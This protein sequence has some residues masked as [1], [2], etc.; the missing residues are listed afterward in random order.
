VK[1]LS[2]A[3]RA[4]CAVLCAAAACG[5]PP[6]EHVAGR[7]CAPRGPAVPWFADATAASGVD[8]E[9]LAADFR[10]GPLAVADTDGDG[11]LDL[12]AGSR[13]GGLAHFRNRGGWSFVD[14]AGA[15][16]LDLETPVHYIAPADLDNDGDPDLAVAGDRILLFE[17]VGR[18]RFTAVASAGDLGDGS[19]VEHLLPVDLDGDG[20]LELY[21]SNRDR[22]D[23]ER[24]RNRLF[25]N[26][27]DLVLAE[28]PG[29]GG[30]D[31]TGLSWTASAIDFDGDGDLDLHVANDTLVAD[32][33][34]SRPVGTDLPPDAFYR[35]DTRP[36]EIRLIDVAADL[37][38]D[39]PRSSMGGLVADF[40]GDRRLDLFIT[41]FGRKKL[42][43]GTAGGFEER[44]EA[45]GVAGT[46]RSDGICALAANQ[47]SRACLLLSWGSQLADFDLDGHDD[48][49]VVNGVSEIDGIPAPALVFR[50]PPPFEEIDAGLG[51]FEGHGLIAA[52]LDDDGDL[53]LA[54]G[55]HNGPL[56]LFQNQTDPIRPSLVLSLEGRRSNREGLGAVIE[57]R[58]AAGRRLVR[59][60]GAGGVSHSAPPPLVHVGLGDD[61][62]ASIEIRWPSG[63]RQELLAPYDPHVIA[64]EPVSPVYSGA[65]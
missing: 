55:T 51:C 64:A 13:S 57:V 40:D 5:D 52:D 33:G 1:R 44:G 18:G 23:P 46:T 30:G 41:D 24:S 49:V 60:L 12:L 31:S 7:P 25:H 6:P 58:T 8:F 20:L 50:G 19:A 17:N 28:V 47:L 10:G 4:A 22:H 65:R 38:L 3:A 45:L 59:A 37:G 42:F 26:R 16:G 32:H 21:V 14:D 53:D 62:A 11:R 61:S 43:A 56:R 39:G 34:Q 63:V 35:N 9:F 48:L 2:I 27:G 54:A 15:V 36:G 29:A